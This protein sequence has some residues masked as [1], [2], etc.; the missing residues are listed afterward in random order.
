MGCVFLLMPLQF[1]KRHPIFNIY[2]FF[3]GHS[4]NIL[5]FRKKLESSVFCYFPNN[6]ES[7]LIS[8]TI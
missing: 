1:L 5:A 8:L 7:S 3:V 6:S 2:L 4:G